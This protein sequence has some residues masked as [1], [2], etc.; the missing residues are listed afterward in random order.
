[1]P[2]DLHDKLVI[3]ISSRALFDLEHENTIYDKDG[4]EEYTKYQVQHENE[5]LQK[6]TAF[7]AVKAL[8]E[9]N[10]KFN[11][12]IV[13]VIVISRNSPETGLRVFNSIEKMKLA[14]SR[15]A[16]TGGENIAKYLSAFNVDLFLSKNEIDD[17]DSHVKPASEE[18]PSGRVL[19]KSDSK[20]SEK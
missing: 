18:I 17:Q 1:M 10:S 3:A 8:L 2:Y 5:I 6:G 7:S 12:P 11:A 20:L 4:L 15:A 14:I 16:F 13:E 19:Y 9:L